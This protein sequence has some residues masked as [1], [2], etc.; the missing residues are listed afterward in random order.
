MTAHP[1]DITDSNF[2]AHVLQVPGPV[3]VDFWAEWAGPCKMIAP[4]LDEIA[5]EY[6]GRLLVP[7]LNID[8]NPKTG[9]ECGLKSVPTLLIFK[10]GKVVATK[11]GAMSKGQLVEFVENNL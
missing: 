1:L 3:V 11:S 2:A 9:P 8:Q 10:A 4:L 7:K 6:E 5:S